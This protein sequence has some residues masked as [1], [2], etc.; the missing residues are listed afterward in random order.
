[1]PTCDPVALN[2]ICAWILKHQ[3]KS[4]LDVGVGFGKWGFLAREYTDV[5]YGRVWK[6]QWRV[7]IHGIEIFPKYV[8]LAAE[9]IYTK[10]FIGDATKLIKDLGQYNLLICSDMLEHL[11]KPVGL[12]FLQDCR[13][14]ADTSFFTTPI[15]PG[16]RGGKHGN[17]HQAHVSTWTKKELEQFGTVERFVDLWYMEMSGD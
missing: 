13:K 16:R 11:Q 1:M 10:I 6:P 12:E 2:Q 14:H 9:H 15:E 5:W 4:I 17:K 8:S 7:A 3:P